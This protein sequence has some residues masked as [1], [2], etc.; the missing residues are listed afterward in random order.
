MTFSHGCM[1]V[2]SGKP[3]QHCYGKMMEG[4]KSSLVFT[5][6]QPSP[7]TGLVRELDT[8]GVDLQDLDYVR[9]V[10]AHHMQTHLCGGEN[11]TQTVLPSDLD[12]VPPSM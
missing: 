9:M 8:V 11:Q 4:Y 7:W 1:E 3:S 2:D 5:H 6:T 12:H 10:G